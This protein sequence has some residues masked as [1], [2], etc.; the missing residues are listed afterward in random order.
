MNASPR[1]SI[2]A[3]VLLIATVIA[4]G[5]LLVLS[6]PQPVHI[7]IQPPA[8]TATITPPGDIE[9][10]VTGAV[11]Q[12]NV[13]I[14]LPYNSRVND[15]LM[16]AGGAAANA[17]LNAVNLA[18]ILRDGDQ[19]H[20]YSIADNRPPAS[21]TTQGGGR[22]RINSASADDL[23]LLPGIGEVLAGRIIERR[24]QVGRFNG[25]ADLDSIEGIGAALIARLEGLISFE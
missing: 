9:V 21:V 10:Y 8:P 19:V 20:V 4:G 23:M 3:F 1:L 16:A 15:A 17:D 22:V 11:N 13:L 24:A 14:R 2:L 5:A 18:A 7:V 25:M 12:P 6:R